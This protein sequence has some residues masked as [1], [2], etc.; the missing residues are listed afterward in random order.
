MRAGVSRGGRA[1]T[2]GAALALCLTGVGQG[3]M[4]QGPRS[5]SAEP[6]EI[7]QPWSRVWR[8][9]TAC[10]LFGGDVSP[11]LAIYQR[12][13]ER[14]LHLS[15]TTYRG[16]AGLRLILWLSQPNTPP[17][18]EP[19]ALPAVA[20][21]EL[22]A[23]LPAGFPKAGAGQSAIVS[24]ESG[25][26]A[27]LDAVAPTGRD[28]TD[29]N[30]CSAEVGRQFPGTGKPAAKP[31]EMLTLLQSIVRADD[32]PASARR[33]EREGPV[34]VS[35]TVSAKGEPVRCRVTRSSG[36]S[37]LDEATCNIF[38]SRAKYTPALDADGRPTTGTMASTMRWSLG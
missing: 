34:T 18:A 15:G 29:L 17:A 6:V 28:L 16:A 37:A 30:R 14:F 7:W 12:G 23:P 13:T 20:G 33:N 32:Y 4:A 21:T 36:T 5:M 9:T 38:S 8:G 27:V 11:G 10:R 31:P 1:L 26:G 2:A 25:A 24:V 35:V 22:L 3:A 19:I